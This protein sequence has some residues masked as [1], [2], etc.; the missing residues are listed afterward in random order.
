[1][2]PEIITKNP[3]KMVKVNVKVETYFLRST[4]F[5][6][7]FFLFKVFYIKYLPPTNNGGKVY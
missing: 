7:L 4:V 2:Q 5:F 3:S 6:T 1:M